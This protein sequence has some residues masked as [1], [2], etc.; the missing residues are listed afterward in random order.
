MFVQLL[1]WI[2]V[3]Q[4]WTGA[5][6]DSDYNR[7]EG[8]LEHQRLFANDDKVEL[9]KGSGDFNVLPFT[10]IYDKGYR[11]KMVAW[12]CGQ[13]LVLQ[14]EWAESD[15]QFRRDQTFLSASVAT[16]RGGNERAVKVCKRAWFIR[17]GFLPNMSPKQLNDA[18][19]TWAFQAN[20]MF[21][22]VL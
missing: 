11:A 12:R 20:F 4:L 8:Y 21:S 14:P 17:R 5:V 1:G 15:K 7:R 3:G 16:D 9:E 13:Q 18:W 22:P 6:S 2:G 19:T 10:N